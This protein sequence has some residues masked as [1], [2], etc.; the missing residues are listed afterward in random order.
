MVF[1]VPIKPPRRPHG[2]LLASCVRKARIYFRDVSPALIHRNIRG[3]AKT[4]GEGTRVHLEIN[5]LS[6]RKN[7]CT[8]C[9]Y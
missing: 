9:M 2:R 1:Y 8:S 4:D 7:M 3:I 6:E 5:G